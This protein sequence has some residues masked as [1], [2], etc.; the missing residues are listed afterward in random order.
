[1]AMN[2]L[3]SVPKLKGRDNYDEWSFAAE[4]LLVLEGMIQYIKPAVPGADIKIADDERTKAKLILT[5]DY[6]ML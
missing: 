3:Q 5:I 6:L 1:M 2:Y 4:N